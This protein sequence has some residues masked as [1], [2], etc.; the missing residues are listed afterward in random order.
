MIAT[1]GAGAAAAADVGDGEIVCRVLSGDEETFGVLVDRHQGLL[2]R[3]AYALVHDSDAA[4]DLVQDAFVRA[5][6]DLRRC[7]EPERFRAW[8]F[9]IL[10]NGCRDYLKDIRRRS[11]PLETHGIDLP[12]GDDPLR[13]A[14]NEEFHRRVVDALAELP[15][16]QR[17]AFL[18]R[19]VEGLSYEEMA[20]TLGTAVSALKMRVLRAR[21]AL[22]SRLGPA[23]E[24]TSEVDAM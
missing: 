18:L 14:E 19:H 9:T 7:R 11:L 13:D 23:Q 8:V 21:H 5:Y 22:V 16:A 24:R 3:Q 1:R 12:S 15:E 4:A 2:F 10:R 20:G 6:R 17:E